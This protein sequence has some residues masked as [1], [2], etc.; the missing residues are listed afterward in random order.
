MSNGKQDAINIGWDEQ[1]IDIGE[2]L[3]TEIGRAIENAC[4]KI[5]NLKLVSH[6]ARAMISLCLVGSWGTW[7]AE[8][9]PQE[10]SKFYE[11]GS[12]AVADDLLKTL[13]EL[14]HAPQKI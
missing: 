6:D 4:K 8:M 9:S 10:A 2:E 14:R 1:L 11:T 13:Q 3:Q 7:L 5:E 12:K